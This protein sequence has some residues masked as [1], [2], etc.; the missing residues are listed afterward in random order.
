[1]VAELT[2]VDWCEGAEVEADVCPV[3]MISISKLSSLWSV[4]RPGSVCLTE[5]WLRAAGVVI[6]VVGPLF[7]GCR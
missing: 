2:E 4:G 5:C 1:M 3:A 6:V 7:D